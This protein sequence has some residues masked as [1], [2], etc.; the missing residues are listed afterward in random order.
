MEKLYAFG[1]YCIEKRKIYTRKGTK[2]PPRKVALTTMKRVKLRKKVFVYAF[3][4]FVVVKM[5]KAR[6]T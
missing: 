2:K 1:Y 3:S 6:L 5:Y 4:M